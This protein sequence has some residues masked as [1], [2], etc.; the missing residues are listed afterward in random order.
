VSQ[1]HG[2]AIQWSHLSRYIPQE[3][4]PSATIN[5]SGFAQKKCSNEFFYSLEHFFTCIVPISF[6]YFTFILVIE[7][8]L[9]INEE[10][11]MKCIKLYFL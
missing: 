11:K 5:L 2:F 8:A 9:I 3:S 6:C 7:T 1:F 10:K 4:P